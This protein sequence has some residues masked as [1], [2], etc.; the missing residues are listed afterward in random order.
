[1]HLLS[2]IREIRGIW[3]L[4]IAVE[5][6]LAF[7]VLYE[8]GAYSFDDAYIYL[9]GARQLSRGELPNPSAG[10]GKLPTNSFSSHLWLLLL[11]P[12]FW[13]K[14]PPLVWAKALG[15]LFLLLSV[16]QAAGILRRLRPTLTHGSSLALAGVFLVFTTSVI[17]S[18]NG[19]ETALNLFSI[20]LLLRFAIRDLLK[21]RLSVALGL[22]AGLHLVT[23]P[24]AFL[25]LAVLGAVIGWCWA[26]KRSSIGWRDVLRV[27]LGALPGLVFFAA[28]A[29]V[30]W[31]FL[32]TS[33]GVKVPS[34]EVMISLLSFKEGFFRVLEDF[35]RTPGLALVYT[36]LVYFLVRRAKDGEGGNGGERTPRLTTPLRLLFLGLALDHLGEF[37]FAGDPIGV[38]RLWL[39][40]AAT[41]LVCALSMLPA[42]CSRRQSLAV[43]TLLVGFTLWAGFLGWWPDVVYHYNHPGSP[44]ER[45]GEFIAETKLDDSWLV[46]MDMGV[47]PYFGDLPTIDSHDRPKCNRYRASNPDDLDYIWQKPVDFVV[48]I[49]PVPEPEPGFIYHGINQLV[50]ADKRFDGFREVLVAEW[51]PPVDLDSLLTNVGRYFHLYVSERI[52]CD[53]GEPVM[54]LRDVPEVE[55]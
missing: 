46:T 40:S 5:I 35:L 15:F 32:P 4:V 11:T 34:P 13:L 48:L 37:F 24:D 38:G 30:Y 25:D 47:V 53:I 23:R 22:A 41:A 3:W 7:I 10:D 21:D 42:F 9:S 16:I 49:T 17:G 29:L 12:A 45:L 52:E 43:A 31:Q 27:K 20:L 14:I 54:L 50:C 44:A 39:P 19:L 55:P 1:M 36:G 8:L 33:A 6:G 28:V 51:R 18:V 26:S 2:A